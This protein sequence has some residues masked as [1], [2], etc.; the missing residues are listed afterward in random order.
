M[1]YRDCLG[2]RRRVRKSRS[3]KNSEPCYSEDKF[4][5]NGDPEEID[6]P[7]AETGKGAAAGD[8]CDAETGTNPETGEQCGDSSDGSTGPGYG[9]PPISP[10]YWVWLPNYFIFPSW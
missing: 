4:D 10:W 3:K 6:C 9:T 1:L 7:P 5:E 2:A 8:E